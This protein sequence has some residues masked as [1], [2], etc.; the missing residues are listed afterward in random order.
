ME[1]KRLKRIVLLFG[2]AL[3]LIVMV[4]PSAFAATKGTNPAQLKIYSV[5]ATTTLSSNIIYIE[6]INFTKAKG[7]PVVTIDNKL[8]KL[9]G[10]AT[11]TT[12]AAEYIAPHAPQPGDY[13]LT[14]TTGSGA[15]DYDE[16]NLTIGAAGSQG[17]AGPQGPIGL[18]GPQGPAG[19]QGAPGPQ[20]SAGSI[21]LKGDT[22]A[23]G[24]QGVQGPVGPT[25][26]TGPIGP[27]GLT[28]PAGTPGTITTEMETCESPASTAQCVCPTSKRLMTYGVQCQPS[29]YIMSEGIPVDYNLR[30]IAYTVPV[31][32]DPADPTTQVIGVAA[33]CNSF[34]MSISYA[35]TEPPMKIWL[36]CY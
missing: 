14:V 22:G 32:S 6:G 27:I 36:L 28:G 34:R 21:G 30:T 1:T 19:P 4:F 16:Y 24:I 20:G 5:D 18:T 10:T 26:A 15:T 8:M 17:P 9:V 31:H 11:D 23:Q 35:E 25:G 13:L 2:V 33:L 3:L 7:A 12:I 29:D